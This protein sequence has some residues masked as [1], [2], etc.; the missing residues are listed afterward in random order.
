M[1]TVVFVITHYFEQ[2]L[3]N[4]RVFAKRED[5][6]TAWY[7][8]ISSQGGSIDDIE[9]AITKDD[10]SKYHTFDDNEF[11]YEEVPLE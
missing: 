5:A 3:E 7:L 4:T 8:D 2:V 1:V 10:F 11:R 6:I 9:I